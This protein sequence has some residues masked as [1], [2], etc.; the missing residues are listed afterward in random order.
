MD[1]EQCYE[2][3]E[4]KKH[5]RFSIL[6]PQTKKCFSEIKCII[7]QNLLYVTYF[8]LSDNG[9]MNPGYYA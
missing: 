5:Q 8:P 4:P 6:G 3:N 1:S 9:N 7:T 2:L